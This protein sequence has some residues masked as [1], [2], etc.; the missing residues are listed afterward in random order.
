M[1]C[2]DTWLPSYMAASLTIRLARRLPGGKGLT[3]F[4]L[5]G[6]DRMTDARKNVL[7]V[8]KAYPAGLGPSDRRPAEPACGSASKPANTHE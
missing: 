4:H 8:L 6:D 2:Q 1:A 5:C 7:A 3:V